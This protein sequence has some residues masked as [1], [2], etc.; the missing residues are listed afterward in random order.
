M[1]TGGHEKS[2]ICGWIANWYTL[3]EF[4]DNMDREICPLSLNYNICSFFRMVLSGSTNSYQ[5]APGSDDKTLQECQ[6][7]L[8]IPIP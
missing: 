3:F 2:R 6:V 7:C 1:K 8:N 4:V 5:L